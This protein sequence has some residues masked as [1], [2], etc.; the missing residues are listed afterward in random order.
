[1]TNDP[2]GSHIGVLMGIPKFVTT[3]IETVVE[4]GCGFYSTMTFLS[5]YP[6]LK[7]LFSLE[8]NPVWLA[9]MQQTAWDTRVQFKQD[10]EADLA[11]F[12]TGLYCDL[13]FIDGATAEYRIISF[14]AIAKTAKLI[15][16][17]DAEQ[18]YYDRVKDSPDF[19]VIT[20]KQLLPWTA[21]YIPKTNTQALKDFEDDYFFSDGLLQPKKSSISN[22]EERHE[23][24]SSS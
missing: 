10:T 16:V 8:S 6:N 4:F 5:S 17:H 24:S 15:V 1:M 14:L 2:F 3:P 21:L 18:N 20:F 11:R 22:I 7:T 9:Q 23:D 13:A 12:A 19:K